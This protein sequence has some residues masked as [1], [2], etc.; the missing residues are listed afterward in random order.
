MCR[1]GTDG[2]SQ[3]HAHTTLFDDAL[4]FGFAAAHITPIREIL[5]GDWLRRK[6][7]DGLLRR[8]FDLFLIVGHRRHL[9]IFG[10]EE[11]LAEF[12]VLNNA[13]L[14]Y[15]RAVTRKPWNSSRFMAS[16]KGG[17]ER[18]LSRASEPDEMFALSY[19]VGGINQ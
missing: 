5:I 10:F 18:T 14:A 4:I 6:R 16:V 17:T 3:R 15:L 12:D 2:L 8:S 11:P 19:N 9:P 7:I 13:S 1:T